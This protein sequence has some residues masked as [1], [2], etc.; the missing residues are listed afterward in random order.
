M[1]TIVDILGSWLK[2]FDFTAASALAATFIAPPRGTR[3]DCCAAGAG[4]KATRCCSPT[5]APPWPNSPP[6]AR[7][8]GNN[9]LGGEHIFFR[10]PEADACERAN[11]GA[12]FY[13]GI[14]GGLPCM[15]VDGVL[16]ITY[17]DH[18]LG[19]VLGVDP[20]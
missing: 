10:F 13:P 2:R 5:K 3:P 15:E 14:H 18:E 8:L 11:R 17:L 16:V 4:R 19:A 7:I 12:D 9:L 6:R 20:P 1:P